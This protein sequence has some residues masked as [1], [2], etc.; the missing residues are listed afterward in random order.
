M[1]TPTGALAPMSYTATFSDPVFSIE[2]TKKDCS[3]KINRYVDLSVGIMFPVKDDNTV[4]MT[5]MQFI[6]VM[7][8][9]STE[10]KGM[11]N[12]G[13]NRHSYHACHIHTD[14][15]PATAGNDFMALLNRK[16]GVI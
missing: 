11:L 15:I 5:P 10:L 12:C 13:K 9:F 6:R 3:S 2:I 1:T 7:N 14:H 4:E 8:M 16:G